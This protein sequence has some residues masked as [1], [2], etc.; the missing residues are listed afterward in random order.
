MSS[1]SVIRL[2][3]TK[4]AFTVYLQCNVKPG[5]SK[6]REGIVSLLDDAIGVCVSAQAKEASRKLL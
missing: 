6:E 5:A 4:S 2:V 3:P 1:R